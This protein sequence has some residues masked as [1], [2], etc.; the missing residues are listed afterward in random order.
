MSYP[1]F[2]D[3]KLRKMIQSKKHHYVP[4]F[5]LKGFT[6]D[7]GM[8]FI[9]D[10]ELDKIWR[11][12]PLNSFAE[13]HRNTGGIPTDDGEQPSDMAE[14][15]LASIDGDAAKVIDLFRKYNPD[16]HIDQSSL[17][18]LQIF[19]ATL[20]WRSPVNDEFRERL[21][22]SLS[23]TEMGFGV[24]HKDTK[25]RSVEMEDRLRGI[26]AFQK[27][28]QA[29]L[30]FKSFLGMNK[31]NIGDLEIYYREN[32]RGVV[33]DNPVLIQEFTD[34]NSLKG[35]LIFP[36]SASYWMILT[37]R[38]KPPTLPPFISLLIDKLQFFNAKRFVACLDQEYLEILVQ[39]Y[40]GFPDKKEHMKKIYDHLTEIFI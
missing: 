16:Y 7:S 4:Q 2:V 8:F 25:E 28:Y 26:G 9:Y 3:Y 1:Y 27:S 34:F 23:F 15:F 24:F 31:N 18:H 39:D 12:N 20:F 33:S 5:Y 6:D 38:G 32:D 40:K 29:F 37:K 30:A 17:L 13:N 21:M 11:T 19:I 14:Q 22:H 36:L 10:K 35:E